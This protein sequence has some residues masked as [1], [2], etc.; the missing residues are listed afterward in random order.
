M[1]V[2]AVVVAMS[3]GA[4]FT[5]ALYAQRLGLKRLQCEDLIAIALWP[6]LL[7]VLLALPRL[8]PDPPDLKANRGV[9]G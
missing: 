9:H 8:A 1:T 5:G 6:F 3:A 2:L 4:Q 7:A